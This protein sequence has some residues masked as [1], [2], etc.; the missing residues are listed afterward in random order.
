MV[1]YR[2]HAGAGPRPLHASHTI[3]RKGRTS[4]VS[5]WPR[6]ADAWVMI[7]LA[8]GV[9]ACLFGIIALLPDFERFGDE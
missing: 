6:C 8:V 1:K 3:P 5:F 4:T 2:A 7:A 9:I